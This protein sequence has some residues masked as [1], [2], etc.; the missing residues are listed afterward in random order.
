MKKMFGSL[1]KKG[2]AVFILMVFIACS[3]VAAKANNVSISDIKIINNGNGDAKISFDLYWENSW[4]VTTGQS[5]YDGVYV[6]FKYRAP[7]TNGLWYPLHLS[8]H[9]PVGANYSIYQSFITYQIPNPSI[10]AIIYRNAAGMGTASFN[11]IILSI[12]TGGLP[13]NVDIK[14]FAI[15]MVYIPSTNYVVM[16]DGNKTQESANAFHSTDNNYGSGYYI[17]NFPMPA[18]STDAN[19]FDDE[20]LNGENGKQIFIS[21]S[22]WSYTND[23]NT[24]NKNWPTG[25][26][27][28]C[29][30]YEIS[31]GGYRDF[32]NTLTT[33]QQANR[34]A[35]PITA[36][37]GTLAMADASGAN[38]TYI[39]IDTPSTGGKPAVYGTD[40][41]GNA[42]YNEASDGEFVACGYLS[43]PD[44]AAY[45]A[46]AGLSPLT[47]IEYE[48]IC[49]GH[50]D[51]GLNVVQYGEYAWGTAQIGTTAYTLTNVSG[52]TE[53]VTNITPG[54]S[55]G[56]ANYSTTTPKNL[57]GTGMPFRNGIFA[58]Y[59]GG[60]NRV[61]SG[62]G[63]FGVMELS[64]NLS[65]P[66]VT[67]GNSTGR[68]FQGTNSDGWV[69]INGFAGHNSYGGWP[70]ASS[71]NDTTGI[72][73]NCPIKYSTGTI[74]RGGNYTSPAAELRVANRSEGQAAAT[75][76]PT[77]GGRG[78]LYI[79]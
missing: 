66:C 4:R 14:A 52:N 41:N 7:N 8:G 71:I 37:R 16:G 29:M 67:F 11:D 1:R 20:Y 47:E 26:A 77:Q 36:V 21:D 15:E 23:P 62:A 43:W 5:N 73:N 70:G 39:K 22:G 57:Y 76:K 24:R 69:D 60:V 3:I 31:Q 79:R 12:Y 44:V 50:T 65:E 38:R 13:Y 55:I 53:I 40:Y 59:T 17:P 49:R 63:F 48:R 46:W 45:L 30:K 64:G 33:Q 51:A 6:F 9:N 35:K 72:C 19:N 34:T 78:V 2:N 27:L 32:I 68:I 61:T 58:A 10:G 25:Q 75:R 18:I 74:L 28:W 42:L 56:M 54:N